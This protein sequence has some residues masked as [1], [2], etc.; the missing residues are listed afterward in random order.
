MGEIVRNT[1]FAGLGIGAQELGKLA[2]ID[3]S[4]DEFL[5]RSTG[6]IL[7][8]N[9]ELLFQGPVLRDFGF[10]FLMVAR[11]EAEAKTI[12]RNN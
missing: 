8:P 4:A 1:G 11:S 3:I 2:G 10:K 12:R 9:A 6:T 5:A 7:N